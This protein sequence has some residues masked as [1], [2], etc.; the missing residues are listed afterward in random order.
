MSSMYRAEDTDFFFF[1]FIYLYLLHNFFLLDFM[2][3]LM[4]GHPQILHISHTDDFVFFSFLFTNFFLYSYHWLIMMGQCTKIFAAW[5][6]ELVLALAQALALDTFQTEWYLKLWTLSVWVFECKYK[7]LL[8][9]D[10][11]IV[12]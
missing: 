9:Y 7:T 5:Q 2:C 1:H 4:D 3:K 10:L 8:L 6:V 11:N 12:C